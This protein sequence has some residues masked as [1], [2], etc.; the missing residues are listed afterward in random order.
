[1]L[2]GIQRRNAFLD[3]L[4][5]DIAVL[6][7]GELPQ[8]AFWLAREGALLVVPPTGGADLQA[9]AGSNGDLQSVGNN[10]RGGVLGRYF[11]FFASSR[12]KER[13]YAHG[14]IARTWQYAIKNARREKRLL[15]SQRNLNGLI[16]FFFVHCG[17]AH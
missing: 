15:G 10:S 7:E 12:S 8:L 6:R 2:D 11:R 4:F 17:Y 3:A 1:M 13:S 14:L 5:Y 16:Q 9:V